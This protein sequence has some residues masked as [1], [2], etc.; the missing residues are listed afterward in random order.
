MIH[1]VNDGKTYH[2]HFD[3]FILGQFQVKITG[4]SLYHQV[5]D[6]NL[7]VEGK[8][9]IPIIYILLVDGSGTPINYD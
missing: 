9:I 3:P 5:F 8:N 1:R 6:V 7:F 4:Y 2:N